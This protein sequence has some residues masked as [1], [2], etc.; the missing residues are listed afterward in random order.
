MEP[1]P[2]TPADLPGLH[3]L[4]S[5][6]FDAPLMVP[7]HA[8]DDGALGRT[9][10]VVEDGAV[11]ASACWAPRTLGAPGGGTLLAG[12]VSNVATAP[13]A[14]GRG[15][16]RRTLDA[17]HAQ[18]RAAGADV[19][20]LFTGTPGVYRS[21]GYT[22][23]EVP[24]RT[25]TLRA[26][27][28]APGSS[29]TPRRRRRSGGGDG[30]PARPVAVT[31][32]RP[33]GSVAAEAAA[34]GLP[35]GFPVRFPGRDA[36]VPWDD[37]HRL[38]RLADTGP[39]GAPRPLATLRDTVHRERRLPLWY[40]DAWLLVA[41]SPAPDG[42]VPP[43][44]LVVGYAVVDMDPAAPAVLRVREVGLDPADADA[45]HVAR[46]L[47]RAAARLGREL[48]ARRAEVR[49]PAEGWADVVTRTLLDAPEAGVDATGM[50][51]PVGA[52]DALVAALV[53]STGRAAT[54]GFHWPGDYL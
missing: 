27:G 38:H 21:S 40:A 42:A 49:L 35:P 1:R 12:G 20:L 4:W 30:A 28:G 3:A 19:A 52:D 51:R 24:V 17:A 46:A 48:G 53:A 9:L 50:L 39:D 2:A 5:A 7:V 36:P 34:R 31:V 54:P 29:G 25:G 44:P 26:D 32:A 16:V 6:A 13:A 14:R 47:A 43:E 33:V 18:M 45:P 22:A 23:F 11:L 8:S 41:R 15:L 10:V 37:L